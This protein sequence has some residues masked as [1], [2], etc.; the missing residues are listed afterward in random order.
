MMR[1]TLDLLR[2]SRQ[3]VFKGT[4]RYPGQKS[5]SLEMKQI[6]LAGLPLIS[7]FINLEIK[8]THVIKCHKSRNQISGWWKDIETGLAESDKHTTSSW[9]LWALN[10][11]SP[12][13]ALLHM[14][15]THTSSGLDEFHVCLIIIR[16]FA[17]PRICTFVSKGTLSTGQSVAWLRA[18]KDFKIQ[19]LKVSLQLTPLGPGGWGA[20]CS[21]TFHVFAY[22]RANTRTSVLKKLDFSQLWVW[23][24]AVRF[25]PHEIISFCRKKIKFVR[26]TKIS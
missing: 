26:N 15:T 21:P 3:H 24:R 8:R 12:H 20:H 11:S 14:E 6:S 2:A 23:K 18:S 16:N 7:T 10:H 1:T 4:M 22:N 5:N 25:L 13:A 17:R 9:V 19:L